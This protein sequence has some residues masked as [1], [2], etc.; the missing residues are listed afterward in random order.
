MLKSLIFLLAENL[1]LWQLSI[2]DS[3]ALQENMWQH[4]KWTQLIIPQTGKLFQSKQDYKYLNAIL[5]YQ[6]SN[7][8]RSIT[9]GKK[10]VWES[11]LNGKKEPL[12]IPSMRSR[13]NYYFKNV[14]TTKKIEVITVESI[15]GR[16]E[17]GLTKHIAWKDYFSS[18]SVNRS[19]ANI[20]RCTQQEHNKDAKMSTE[21]QGE[22]IWELFTLSIH[23]PV[24][25]YVT[26]NTQMKA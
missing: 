10:V 1:A 15:L 24:S 14:H 8:N 13:F 3:E 5:E 19:D 26:M 20:Q 2:W 12:F 18:L 9:V 11:S 16:Q 25:K 17:F 7:F 22:T 23:Y 21:K 6:E 4:K